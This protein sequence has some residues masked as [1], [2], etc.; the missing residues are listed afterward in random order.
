M[1]FL[2]S[3]SSGCTNLPSAVITKYSIT[4]NRVITFSTFLLFHIK[5]YSEDDAWGNI[6]G[7]PNMRGHTRTIWGDIPG[8][9]DC[10]KESVLSPSPIQTPFLFFE[11]KKIIFCNTLLVFRWAV[12]N[13]NT[14]KTFVVQLLNDILIDC[15]G[16]K[17]RKFFRPTC[18]ERVGPRMTLSVV[19]KDP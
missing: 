4:V 8:L 17:D 18:T 3:F 16:R 7:L 2:I 1:I 9:P 11:R 10:K 5:V 6:P 14:E 15:V 12:S 13:G 19:S